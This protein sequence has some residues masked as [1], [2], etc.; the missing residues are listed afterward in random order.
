MSWRKFINTIFKILLV[1]GTTL[2]LRKNVTGYYIITNPG[3]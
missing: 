1:T 3:I 2:L